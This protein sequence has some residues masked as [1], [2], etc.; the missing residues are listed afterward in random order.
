MTPLLNF[1]ICPYCSHKLK[2][3]P[4][5]LKPMVLSDCDGYMQCDVCNYRSKLPDCES[6]REVARQQR[7]SRYVKNQ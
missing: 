5:Q 2:L 1:E 4:Y 6:L 3:E 7:G